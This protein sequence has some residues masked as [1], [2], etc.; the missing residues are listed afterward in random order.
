MAIWTYYVL[1]EN[2]P[3]LLDA[4]PEPGADAD[5]RVVPE[6]GEIDTNIFNSWSNIVVVPGG[7]GA[8]ENGSKTETTNG[9]ETSEPSLSN[10]EESEES[11]GSNPDTENSSESASNMS[12]EV[13]RLLNDYNS[14]TFVICQIIAE[15]LHTL[16]K[17]F[18]ILKPFWIWFFNFYQILF[19]M[20]TWDLVG[21]ALKTCF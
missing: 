20:I 15:I 9:V 6:N 8:A 2:K 5:R 18:K 4:L 17:T 3:E 16:K 14:Q 7:V 10:G 21:V 1:R 12:Q 11:N 13:R 19:D